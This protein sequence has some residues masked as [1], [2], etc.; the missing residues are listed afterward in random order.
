MAYC[1]ANDV[2]AKLNIPVT[3]TSEDTAITSFIEQADSSIDALLEEKGF[4][5]PLTTV[6][7]IIK[8]SSADLAA[9][10]FRFREASPGEIRSR[11]E[12]AKEHVEAYVAQKGKGQAIKLT[13]ISEDRP[14]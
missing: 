14:L 1:T 2:K 12:Q 10:L 7:S 4:T 11:Y 13:E 9:S 8:H 6:P 5:V 3:D